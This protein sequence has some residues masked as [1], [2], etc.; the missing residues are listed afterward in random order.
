[1]TSALVLMDR[2]MKGLIEIRESG[3]VS[4]LQ[5]I[6]NELD[7]AGEIVIQTVAKRG[8]LQCPPTGRLTN[9]Q[10]G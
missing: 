10:A 8:C 2:V 1:M 7:A 3:D 5:H 6:I 4:K 9:E